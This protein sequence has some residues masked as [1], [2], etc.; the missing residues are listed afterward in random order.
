MALDLNI[1]YDAL[2]DK[3]GRAVNEDSL[4]ISV[5]P[6]HQSFVLCDGLGGHGSGDV[7]S[8]L[9]AQKVRESLEGAGTLKESFLYAQE[10]LLLKQEREHAGASMKTTA[11][12]LDIRENVAT[13]AHV[14]D[15]RIYYFEK[16]KYILRSQDHSIPQMLVKRGDIREKDI[17]RHED[18]NRL[19]RVMGTKGEEL[20]CEISAPIA[21]TGQT[22]FLLCS[23]GFWEL[24]D[25]RRMCRTLR[26]SKT[27]REWLQSMEKIVLK[28]GKGTNMDNYSAIA[29]FVRGEKRR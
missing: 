28:N 15:S 7:A 17:R 24:V 1:T 19:L 12:V 5:A 22:S 18:R 14:G 20:K 10:A 23:D 25:E 13:F 11:A 27:P 29:V 16:S 4:D 8:R 21:V 9:V 3:G 26:K 6:M 2:T